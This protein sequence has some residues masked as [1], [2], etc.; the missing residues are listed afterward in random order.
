MRRKLDHL[1]RGVRWAV[2]ILRLSG[3]L[4]IIPALCSSV[5]FIPAVLMNA[6]NPLLVDGL[7]LLLGIPILVGGAMRVFAGCIESSHNPLLEN[8]DSKKEWLRWAVISLNISAIVMAFATFGAFLGLIKL[9]SK[10]GSGSGPATGSLV[11]HAL[12][13][14]LFVIAAKQ[15][16]KRISRPRILLQGKMNLDP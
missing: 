3:S 13:G 2:R 6:D 11:A 5:F 9:V 14:A 12:V 16:N 10:S 1:P 15:I 4:I 8:H 7:A